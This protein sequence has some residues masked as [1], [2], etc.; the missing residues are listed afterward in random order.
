[1]RK[2]MQ[3]INVMTSP[4]NIADGH[5]DVFARTIFE[6]DRVSIRHNLILA[7]GGAKEHIHD[8][9]SHHIFFVI[10]GA[11]CVTC[12]GKTQ[13]FPVGHAFW[14]E[15]GEAHQVCGDGESDA[16]YITVNAPSFRVFAKPHNA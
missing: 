16:E 6:D 11:L 7:S 2:N 4:I 14:F 3:S 10:K 5:W 9:G 1:M 13:I 15:P 8:F 12:G